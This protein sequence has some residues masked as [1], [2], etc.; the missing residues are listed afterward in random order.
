MPDPERCPEHGVTLLLRR[1]VKDVLPV[2]ASVW[3]ISAL[4]PGSPKSRP[5]A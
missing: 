5:A 3:S 4:L 1:N 2:L